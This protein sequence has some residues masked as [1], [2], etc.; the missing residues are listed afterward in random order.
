MDVLWKLM[1]SILMMSAPIV[2]A[3]LG[4]LICEKSGIVNIG[5]E[6]LLNIGAFTAALTHFYLESQT[7]LSLPIALILA[8]IAGLLF[9]L[10]HAFTCVSMKAN[11]II[12]GTGINLLASGLTVFFSQLLF[13]KDR[14]DPFR[15]GFKADPY[16]G[17]YPT[18]YI[19]LAV[20]LITWY[21]LYKRRFGLRLR[22][23][24]EYPQAAESAGINVKFM[25]YF[26]VLASGFLSGLAGA[27]MV[28][29]TT[30]QYDRNLINGTGFIALAAISFGRWIPKGVAGASLLF[31]FAS[32]YAIYAN[33]LQ[34][35]RNFIP[36]EFF[37]ALPY[38]LTF[39]SLVIFSIIDKRRAKSLT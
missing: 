27:C 8:S 16:L 32:A 12:S 36:S 7:V 13:R 6:G 38:I 21:L 37:S 4:G 34:S 25:Q 24:G 26:G 5:I 35:L 20:F 29:S 9:S 22:A 1:P 33:G 19:A 10:I 2:I 30:I 3:S 28:L 31:G 11:Q 17:I 14:T 39:L 15:F 23:C 18:A